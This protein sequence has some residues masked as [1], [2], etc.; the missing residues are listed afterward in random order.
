MRKTGIL[1]HIAPRPGVQT[2]VE[3]KLKTVAELL[4]DGK[5]DEAADLIET[6]DPNDATYFNVS[7]ISVLNKSDFANKYLNYLSLSD[8]IF[9]L[10]NGEIDPINRRK[11]VRLKRFND[12]S[13]VFTEVQRYGDQ[14]FFTELLGENKVDTISWLDRS[15]G[16]REY[17][18]WSFEKVFER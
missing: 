14:Q 6:I 15:N 13:K 7:L 9:L 3:E 11:I 1:G 5:N 17:G 10:A 16:W 8:I 4:K 2:N 18:L 12:A